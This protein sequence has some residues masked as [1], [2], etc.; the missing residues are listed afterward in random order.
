MPRLGIEAGELG[1]VEGVTSV[2]ILTGLLKLF[3][4]YV[5][6][7]VCGVRVQMVWLQHMLPGS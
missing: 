3:F 1:R 2:H 6:Y 7:G 4:R 5:S